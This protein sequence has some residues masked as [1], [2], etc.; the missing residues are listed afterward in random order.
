M[1]SVLCRPISLRFF[2]PLSNGLS[3]IFHDFLSTIFKEVIQDRFVA[4]TFSR[5]EHLVLKPLPWL[6]EASWPSQGSSHTLF[7]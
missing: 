4:V 2:R 7:R 6:P 5:V 1:K 3:T